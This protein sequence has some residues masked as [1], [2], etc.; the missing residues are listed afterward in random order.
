ML[1]S[2]LN[3]NKIITTVESGII[4]RKCSKQPQFMSNTD[5]WQD[6]M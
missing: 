3:A 5:D 1:Y 2:G 6:F 4:K